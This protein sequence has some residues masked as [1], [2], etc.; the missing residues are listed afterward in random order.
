MFVRIRV[1]NKNASPPSRVRILCKGADSIM[2]PRLATTPPA[3]AAAGAVSSSAANA[4]ADAT[5]GNGSP[6]LLSWTSDGG[7]ARLAVS[8]GSRGSV[9]AGSV[10]VVG[11]GNGGGGNGDAALREEAASKVSTALLLR[12]LLCVCLCVFCCCW[13][14]IVDICKI[15]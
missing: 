14:S 6:P 7:G 2:I 15:V 4:D 5:P 13:L 3:Q 8:D 1:E 12:W 9:L 11:G 10:A